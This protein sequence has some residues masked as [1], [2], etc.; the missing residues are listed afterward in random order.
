MRD[1]GV[2]G[3]RVYCSDY[4]CN[5]SGEISSGAARMMCACRT[6]KRCSCIRRAAVTAAACAIV[7]AVC[8]HYLETEN[9]PLPNKRTIAPLWT[10]VAK[11]LGLS[12]SQMADDDLKQ[13]LSGSI[14]AGVGALRTHEGS[15][16]GH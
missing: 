6:S 11:N 12:P 15:A 10:E 4:R 13:I 9:I 2:R 7:K 16:N 1:M 3:I 5:R 8:K 14:A